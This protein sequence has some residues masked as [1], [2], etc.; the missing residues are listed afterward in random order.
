MRVSPLNVVPLRPADCRIRYGLL[1]AAP[2][3]LACTVPASVAVPAT[4]AKLAVEA[5]TDTKKSAPALKAKL[6]ATV[7][8]V[9][10]VAA[11]P[12]D[13]PSAPLPGAK[14]PPVSTCV[15]PTVPT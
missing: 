9:P 8:D 1:L 14:V 15:A 2:L 7:V 10:G 3:T 6:R 12:G 4:L 11:G 5:L 13:P